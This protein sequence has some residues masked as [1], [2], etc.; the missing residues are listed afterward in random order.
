MPKSMQNARNQTRKA[1][2][3][4]PARK[5]ESQVTPDNRALIGH[6]NF[7]YSCE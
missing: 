4:I 3:A 6:I 5:I 7:T 2:N 1:G